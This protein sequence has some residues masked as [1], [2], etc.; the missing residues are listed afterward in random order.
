MPRF[1]PPPPPPGPVLHGDDQECDL[2]RKQLEAEFK[3]WINMHPRATSTEVSQRNATF[4]VHVFQSTVSC[5]EEYEARR[6]DQARHRHEQAVRAAAVGLRLSLDT[7]ASEVLV[8][9]N[10]Q[11]PYS[12]GAV[13]VQT[14]TDGVVRPSA[15]GCDSARARQGEVAV[16]RVA[17]PRAHRHHVG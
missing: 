11:N 1:S 4:Q 6:R 5:K 14:K 17:E 12:A 9:P 15:G 3:H 10:S 7:G 2:K 8:Q 16:D 13:S